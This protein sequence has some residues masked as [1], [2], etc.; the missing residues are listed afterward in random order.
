MAWQAVKIVFNDIEYY[1]HVRDDLFS[2]P[3]SSG[4]EVG[5]SFKANGKTYIATKATNQLQRDEV[6]LVETKEKKSGKPKT[7]RDDPSNGATEVLC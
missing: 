6:L 1:S 2:I 4:L 5:D 7:R 3:F